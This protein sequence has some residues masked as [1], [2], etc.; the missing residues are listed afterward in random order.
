MPPSARPGLPPAS[1][2]SARSRWCWRAQRCCCVQAGPAT[3][4]PEA[5]TSRTA[6]GL[7]EDIELR[8]AGDGVYDGEIRGGWWTPR[9]PLGGYVMA[10]MLNG[11]TL[12]VDDAARM[13]RSCTMQ[14]LR[15]PRRG[16]V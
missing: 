2:G 16:P 4:R 8:R 10:V 9:G 3:A 6:L 5:V 13:P 14:F 1:S 7:D 12:A 15:P 11:L